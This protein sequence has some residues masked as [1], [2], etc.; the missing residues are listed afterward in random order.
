MPS[1]GDTLVAMQKVLDILGADQGS[2]VRRALL[3]LEEAAW[4]AGYEAAKAGYERII[5]S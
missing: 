2:E 3:D 1:S 5:P 4:S